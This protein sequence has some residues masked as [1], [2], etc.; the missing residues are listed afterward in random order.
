MKLTIDDGY[1]RRLTSGNDHL[2]SYFGAQL[3]TC[4]ADET[5]WLISLCFVAFAERSAPGSLSHRRKADCFS[6]R[7]PCGRAGWPLSWRSGGSSR[8][9]GARHNR[10]HAAR[11][12]TKPGNRPI[13]EKL[14]GLEFNS[15]RQIPAAR[16]ARDADALI[17]TIGAG[18]SGLSRPGIHGR[19]IRVPRLD[20]SA[21]IMGTNALVPN[22]QRRFCR[23]L[24]RHGIQAK[25]VLRQCRSIAARTN[26]N[27][28][29]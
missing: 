5:Q 29:H 11:R 19:T 28:Q 6:I 17:P 25:T 23:A 15:Y 3:T 21:G 20:S 18:S 12:N 22:R 7:R 2:V 26:H 4:T 13:D 27:Q 1:D 8:Q 9:A 10:L 16:C 14:A 24:I